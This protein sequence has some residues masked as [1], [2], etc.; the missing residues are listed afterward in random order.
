MLRPPFRDVHHE[1]AE[2]TAA[3]E[4]NGC[5]VRF[6]TLDALRPRTATFRRTGSAG[7]P[8]RS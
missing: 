7:I 3:Q 6:A 8:F 4:V 2:I 1:G 5:F